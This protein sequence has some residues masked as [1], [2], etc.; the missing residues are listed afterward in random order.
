MIKHERCYSTRCVD[1]WVPVNDGE[2]LVR[3][4]YCVG[5]FKGDHIEKL[6]KQL[7][8]AGERISVLSE[9]LDDTTDRLRETEREVEHQG[10]LEDVQRMQSE[11]VKA[12]D[13]TDYMNSGEFTADD[14]L[15]EIRER[16]GADKKALTEANA[17]DKQWSMAWA[18]YSGAYQLKGASHIETGR[19]WEALYRLGSRE[20]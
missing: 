1:G 5:L 8:E 12:L 4:P 13:L 14:L 2:S 11:I 16:A 17:R 6:V 15:D 9:E 19:A 7:A 10:Y 3:C 18:E 20:S